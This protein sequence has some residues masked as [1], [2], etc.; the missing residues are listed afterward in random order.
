MNVNDFKNL[1]GMK[2]QNG[3]LDNVWQCSKC[4]MTS[5]IGPFP[6]RGCS[7]SG[8]GSHYWRKVK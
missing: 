8:G 6:L 1:S 3:L 7:A 5:M 4:G 2:I